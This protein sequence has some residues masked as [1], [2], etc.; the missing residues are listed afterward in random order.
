MEERSQG[1]M[2]EGNGRIHLKMLASYYLTLLA[3]ENKPAIEY[4]LAT[5]VIIVVESGSPY[6]AQAVL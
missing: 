2:C 6:V 3:F 4:S 5:A 1:N